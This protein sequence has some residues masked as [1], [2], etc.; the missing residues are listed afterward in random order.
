MRFAGLINGTGIIEKG[1]NT[2]DANSTGDATKGYDVS[3]GS[4]VHDEINQLG[5]AKQR[6]RS[7]SNRNSNDNN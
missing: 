1:I 6:I 3:H 5:T 4:Y 7:E 2:Q